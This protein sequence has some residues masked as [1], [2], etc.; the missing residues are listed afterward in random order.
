[1]AGSTYSQQSKP[2]N[3]TSKHSITRFIESNIG[4]FT[5]LQ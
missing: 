1:M 2:S 4:P 3:C 5:V